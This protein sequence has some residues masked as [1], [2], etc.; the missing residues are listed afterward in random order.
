MTHAGGVVDRGQSFFL[1]YKKG[2]FST[3]RNPELQIQL[4]LNQ[5]DQA[6]KPGR[7]KST[8]YTIYR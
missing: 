6:R 8:H 3:F 2:E 7:M 5:G 4:H 1:I